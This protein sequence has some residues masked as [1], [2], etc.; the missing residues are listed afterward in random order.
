MYYDAKS[1]ILA[2][3][4]LALIAILL[5][6]RN[7]EFDR[8]VAVFIFIVG[9][10]QLIEY[11]VR[12]GADSKQSGSAIFVLL[13]LQTIVLAIGT[14]IFLKSNEIEETKIYTTLSAY[15]LAAFAIVFI[16]ALFYLFFAGSKIQAKLAESGHVDWSNN[17][18]SILGN[19]GW[20]YVAGLFIPFILILG[21]YDWANLGVML[22]ILYGLASAA[23]VL[24]SFPPEAFGSMWCYLAIGFAF[25]VWF[26]GIFPRTS[27]ENNSLVK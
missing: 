6:Y 25:L 17:G 2:W 12:S 18:S 20:L 24:T 7:Q 8:A 13:W 9:L 11:G 10:I 1:S 14:Y 3:W 4:I 15:N 19:W 21:Y 23:Y 22:L 26:I 27:V 5:W 16:V